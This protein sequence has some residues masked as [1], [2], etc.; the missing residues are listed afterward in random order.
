M[1]RA[2][3]LSW[4]MRYVLLCGLA[5][6]SSS[7]IAHANSNWLQYIASYGD[8]IRALGPDPAAGQRHYIEHGLSEGRSLDLF[9]ENQYLENYLDLQNALG[10]DTGAATLHFIQH[11][12]A[13]GRTAAPR[14]LTSAPDIIVMLADDV[15]ASVFGPE[16]DMGIPTPAIDALG[17]AG[18]T[19]S[20]GYSA[21]L[22]VPSRASLLTGRW[23]QRTDNGA[24]YGNSPRLPV[25]AVTLAERMGALGY[26]TAMI[27]K[28]HLGLGTHPMDQGFDRFYG[29]RRTEAP[30]LGDDPANPLLDNRTPIANPGYTTDVLAAEA[31]RILRAPRAQPVFLYVAFTAAH[32]PLQTTPAQLAAVP[33][34]IRDSR[35]RDFAATI[36]GLDRGVQTIVDAAKPNS[37]IFFLGDNGNATNA[38]LRGK[39]G[40]LYE[41]GIR[42]PFLMRWVGRLPAGQRVDSPVF[43]TDIA[44]TAMAAAGAPVPVELDGVNLLAPVPAERPIF[45]ADLHGAGY[46]VRKGPWKLLEGYAGKDVALYDLATDRGE[47]SDLS[48]QFPIK[49]GE[50]RAELAAWR[51]RL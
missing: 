22:C 42:V 10:T 4:A 38:P 29:F 5:L 32:Y 26:Y 13:E 14:N 48:A 50:L 15:G 2:R 11:G 35:A 24:I 33:D 23:S 28:W 18:V 36:M 25:T 47:T 46:A 43:V 21:P 27:G 12:Y 51:S 34:T 37:L 30:Y 45:F 6:G 39:K 17:A 8:L 16:R 40:E 41:G 20:Q 31:A 19:F 1:A 49:V 3:H 7:G 44:A 9:D